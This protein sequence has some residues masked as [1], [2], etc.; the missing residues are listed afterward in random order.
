MEILDNKRQ[1]F[2][3][4]AVAGLFALVGCS[5]SGKEKAESPLSMWLVL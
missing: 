3:L 2:K 4:A 5:D 1:L